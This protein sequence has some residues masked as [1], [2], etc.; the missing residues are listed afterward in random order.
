MIKFDYSISRDEHDN[1]RTFVPNLP[2]VIDNLVCIEG[3]NSSG[4]STLLHILALGCHGLKN[5]D[6]KPSLKAKLKDLVSASHQRL[7]YEFT[8][9]NP[10]IGVDLVSSKTEDSEDIQL[11]EVRDGQKV[12]LS[13]ETFERKYRL[14][15]DIPENPLERLDELTKDLHS[16]Q[17]EISRGVVSLRSILRD[18]IS[19]VKH[20][21]DPKKIESLRREVVELSSTITSHTAMLGNLRNDKIALQRLRAAKGFADATDEVQR[22]SESLEHAERGIKDTKKLERNLHI[23]LF[24]SRHQN[25]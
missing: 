24:C 21:R 16:R 22:A 6:L 12:R 20:A 2:K 13:P 17:V 15:Y 8:I 1:H 18:Y 23:G 11:W 10:H 19:E 3:P 14:I 9:S 25:C 5:Q 7:K 4:K